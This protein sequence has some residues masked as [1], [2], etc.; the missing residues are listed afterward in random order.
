MKFFQ[1][2]NLKSKKNVFF[3]IFGLIIFGF[4]F[5]PFPSRAGILDPLLNVFLAWPTLLIGAFLAL[6]IILSGAFAWLAGALLDWVTS[7]NFISFSYTNPG[8]PYRNPIIANGLS[9]TQSLVNMFLVVVLI[10]TAV[11]IALRLGGETGAKKLLVRLIFIAL[12]VNFAPVI[13]GLIVDASNILMNYF[14]VGIREGVSGILSQAVEFGKTLISSLLKI[15]GSFADRV[16]LLTQGAIQ[17]ILN[18]AI[19]LAFLL[20]AGIFL[21]RYFAI[22]IL[23]VLAPLAFVAWILPATKK[24]WNMW[25]NNFLQ[26]S[27]IGITMAFF[28][29]LGMSTFG[30]LRGALMNKITSPGIDPATVGLFDSI[31]PFI[32]V[33]IF[34]FLGFTMGLATSAMGASQAIA[35]TKKFRKKA[36]RLAGKAGGALARKYL[37]AKGKEWMEKQA[38]VRMGETFGT[39]KIGKGIAKAGWAVGLTPAVWAVRRG[40]GE[41]GLKWTESGRADIRKAEGKY[42][43]T[44][45][46]RK[47]TGLRDALKMKDFAKASGILRQG[48]EE[49]Q[50]KDL[51]KLGLTED[52]I[53]KIG[54]E[55]IRTHPEEVK[56]IRDAFPNLAK[57]IGEGFT[58]NIKEKAGL[59]FIPESKENKDLGYESLMDKIMAGLTPEKINKMDRSILYGK[60]A[61][62]KAKDAMHKFWSREQVMAA[63]KEFGRGFT[64][65]F[66]DD[67]K[68]K[69]STQPDWYDSNNTKLS[70]KHLNRHPAFTG[71]FGTVPEIGEKGEKKEAWAEITREARKLEEEEKEKAPRGRPG[72]GVEKKGGEE[73]EE[74]KPP[75]GRGGVGMPE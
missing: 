44:T 65:E 66:M 59:D 20:F 22:W 49:G 23:V 64:K 27:I 21:F 19:M 53:V 9:I 54:R 56:K 75:R 12:I 11:S 13:C 68:T 3:L 33:V 46:E 29:Y 30:A 40:F 62:K 32:A 71:L 25:W 74:K 8:G 51:T 37:G 52:E 47:L 48:V 4:L 34:L 31:L 43:D 69:I 17:I 6:A 24:I 70:P 35:L 39:G 72:I 2:F 61:D 18:L 16:G 38:S 15:T 10:Y 45:P 7:P 26:W 57:K 5:F 60:D 36:G 28:L 14:L 50:I 55:S 58:D 42:K 63:G 67:Y 41:A 1:K 73:E